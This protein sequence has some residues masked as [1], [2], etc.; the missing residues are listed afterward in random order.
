MVQVL[1][2]VPG[3]GEKLISQLSEAGSNVAKTLQQKNAITALQ[4]ALNPQVS[5]QFENNFNQQEMSPVAIQNREPQESLNAGK[6]F[7]IYNAA[8]KAVGPEG[9]K[10]L[11][12]AFLEQ[13]KLAAKE[14]T[15]IG[16]EGRQRAEKFNEKIST[17]RD[18]LPDLETSLIRIQDAL[19]SKDLKSVQNFLADRF[20]NDYLRTSSS[21]A[22]NSA[23]KEF[24]LADLGR[25]KG[26]RPNQF[27]E[28][29]LSQSYAKAGYD[30]KAND[31]IF[32]AMESGVDIKRKEIEI[33]DR[34]REQYDS[35][36]KPL[37]SNFENLVYKELRPYVLNKEKELTK[38]YKSINQGK[39]RYS[40]EFKSN[41]PQ[42]KAPMI[43]PNGERVFIPED[44]IEQALEEGYKRV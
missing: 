39:G 8:E 15:E 1:P 42:G 41:A 28:Q 43:G 3:F 5:A 35:K 34:I 40:S 30:P 7:Q 32:S 44:Q 6:V 24:L 18:A 25:I 19:S 13:Q 10:Q 4:Q 23:V 27:L 12:N 36:G 2:Y 31:K 20:N 11:A 16:K 38:E 29:Q 22:L 9:A 37:P 21:A 26:G 17:Y 14:Q 33:A